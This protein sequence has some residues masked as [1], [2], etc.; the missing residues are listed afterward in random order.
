MREQLLLDFGWKFHKGDLVPAPWRTLSKVYPQ[1]KSENAQGAA[2]ATYYDEDWKQV[3]LPHDYMIENEVAERDQTDCHGYLPR[4]IG[5]YRRAF[6]LEEPDRQRRIALR[7][8]GVATQCTVWVNNHLLKRSFSGYSTFEIDLTDYVEFGDNLNHI[9][10]RVDSIPFEGW[11]YE[12]GGM[13]RHDWLI[14]TDKVA[15][16]TWGTWVK[17]EKQPDGSWLVS[18]E[19]TVRNDRNEETDITIV[20]EIWDEAGRSHG[21][22]DVSL[23]VPAR[24]KTVIPQQLTMHD[25]EL[26]SVDNPHLY[27]LRTTLTEIDQ[28]MDH[29]D[30]SFGF[31]TLDFI[32]NKGFFLN[33]TAV[34]LKGVN[35]H[36]DHAGIGVAVPERVHEF[37]LRRLKEM[38]CNAY[39]SSHHPPT[40]ELL[41]LCDR[42]GILVMDET[43]SFRS[44]EDGFTELRDMI[45]RDR[46]HP[47]VFLWSIANEEPLQGKDRGRR[48]AETMR[49]HVKKLDNTR[50]V[51]IA[52]N[53]G[54][55]ERQTTEVVDIIGINY[56]MFAYDPVYEQYPEKLQIASEGGA[57]RLTRGVYIDNPEKGHFAAYDLKRRSL[58]T[59]FRDLW[60]Q[61]N[62]RDFMAGLFIWSGMDYRGETVWPSLI[63]Q[64][65]PIDICGFPKDSFYLFQSFW[66]D[67]P[68]IHIVP[69]WNWSNHDGDPVVVWVYA[70]SEEAELFHNGESLGV[71]KLEPYE[72]GKWIVPYAAGEL[73]AV[74]RS[75]GKAVAEKRVKTT[76]EPVR[77][78]LKLEQTELRA[79]GQDVAVITVSAVDAEGLEVPTCNAEVECEVIEHGRYLGGA[80]GDPSDHTPAFSSRWKM[81]NGLCQFIVRSDNSPGDLHVRVKNDALGTAELHIKRE[82][83]QL[84]PYVPLQQ[85]EWKITGWGI[86]DTNEYLKVNTRIPEFDQSAREASIVFEHIAG[87]AKVWIGHYSWPHD[88]AIKEFRAVKE[89]SEPGALKIELPDMDGKDM[90]EIKVWLEIGTS[91]DELGKVRWQFDSKI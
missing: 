91:L 30:T 90:L 24:E 36:Q 72:P 20:S 14:K 47:C 80:N 78:K 37:R 44:T 53:G 18:V 50:P 12:G 57:T 49:F 42:L 40:P 61:V 73:V 62:T 32:P 11:W 51:T 43:R 21:Q 8:D 74:A 45:I 1:S 52:L 2:T 85:S 41:D 10:V 60:K 70:N 27:C 28:E 25:P 81:F 66:S 69:H 13:Y 33:G 86:S 15:V 63:Y 5:W 79:D 9:A 48:I 88:H 55:L 77:I 23:K 6:R 83:D 58:G 76:G 7:F 54:F 46:N 87:K 89:T 59:T 65:A 68:M 38:G 84:H 71:H 82:I 26:W 67:Q 16:D 34:K 22:D 19:T 64:G 29:Y 31:R 75:G 35:M 56:H 3:D 39:R 4:G 17:P